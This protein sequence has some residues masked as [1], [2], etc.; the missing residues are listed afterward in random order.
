MSRRR[1]AVKRSV[2]PDPKFGSKKLSKFINLL[3]HNGEK[4]VAEK[5]VY[6][7]LDKALVK[8]VRHSEGSFSKCDVPD[9]SFSDSKVIPFFEEILDKVV[10]FVEVRSR[11]FG[12]ATYQIPV[13]VDPERRGLGLAM[14]WI[15]ESARKRSEKSMIDRLSAE[16]L[17]VMQARGESIAKKKNT[18]KMAKAN[19][20]F[21]HLKC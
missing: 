10:P 8:R 19:Q 12:G 4:S 16:M 15:I 9:A 21:T 7:A 14:R 5:I 1:A 3:M 18:H 2:L 6:N 11:R 17:D 20:A 13:P